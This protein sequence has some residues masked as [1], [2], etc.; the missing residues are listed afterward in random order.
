MP[1]EHHIGDDLARNV[2]ANV[3]AHM[4]E[5][6]VR[7]PVDDLDRAPQQ[8]APPVPGAQWDE[9]HQRWESW[10]EAAGEWV[11]VGDGP[12]IGPPPADE[13]PLP[14]LL[15]REVHLADEVDPLEEHVPDVGRLPE[16]PD[17]PPG[18]QWNEVTGRWE[19]WDEDA[20]A[21]VPIPDGSES[22]G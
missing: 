12:G 19:R 14:P 21:W 2:N 4:G 15:S 3:A 5:R 16:P 8:G 1:E 6:E 18:G 7:P 17:A 20:E 13:N 9:V 11:V 10:D 22:A